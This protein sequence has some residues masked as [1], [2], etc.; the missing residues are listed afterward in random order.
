MEGF[1]MSSNRDFESVFG[2]CPD[3]LKALGLD[4]KPGNPFDSS[5]DPLG[6]LNKFL[7]DPKKFLDDYKKGGK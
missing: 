6:D 2:S 4:G 5:P 7:S 1:S 3:L